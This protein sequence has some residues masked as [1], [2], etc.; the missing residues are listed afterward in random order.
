[1]NI[2]F[3]VLLVILAYTTLGLNLGCIFKSFGKKDYR[4][5]GYNMAG[6]IILI[7]GLLNIIF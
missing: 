6:V 2:I 5:L 4:L 3:T 7:I 1:M